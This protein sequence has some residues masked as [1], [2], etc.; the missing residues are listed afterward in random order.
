MS[1]SAVNDVWRIPGITPKTIVDWFGHDLK[2]A[3]KHYN[4]TTRQDLDHALKVDPFKDSEIA[5]PKSG[6][7]G[8]N[9]RVR[10]NPGG[11]TLPQAKT[12]KPR[13][14][15]VSRGLIAYTVT[16]TGLEPVLPA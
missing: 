3:M 8:G 6:N 9:I 12:Q 14:T 15:E 7:T 4:R 5:K 13:E 2:T 11:N 16:P 1:L 10:G